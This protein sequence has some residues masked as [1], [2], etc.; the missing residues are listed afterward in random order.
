MAYQILCTLASFIW[1]LQIVVLKFAYLYK[2]VPL[3]VFKQTIEIIIMKFYYFN[4]KH[5]KKCRFFM[6]IVLCMRLIYLGMDYATMYFGLVKFY[7]W[8]E[9]LKVIDLIFMFY[10]YS[11][12][13]K[14]F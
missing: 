7:L 4:D 12:R 1:C 5:C 14:E 13:E 9:V 10:C 11:I 2:F 6:R 8:T 3:L